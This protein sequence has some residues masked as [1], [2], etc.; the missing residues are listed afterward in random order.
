MTEYT[1]TAE[2]VRKLRNADSVCFDGNYSDDGNHNH[3]RAIERGTDLMHEQTYFIRVESRLTDYRATPMPRG[4]HAFDMIHSAQFSS[5]WQ[6]IATHITAGCSLMLHW[7]RNNGSPVTDEAGLVVDYLNLL[8]I[9]P[10]RDTKTYRI[11][12]YVGR[13]N[14]ARMVR[15]Y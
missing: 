12:D 3:I 8:V 4:W 1:L 14:I 15:P 11:R 10:N 7:H 2:D 13:D 9:K 6:T 5:E